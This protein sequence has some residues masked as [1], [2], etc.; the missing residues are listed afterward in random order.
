MDQKE[1]IIFNQRKEIQLLKLENAY[2]KD[3]LTKYSGGQ[4]TIPSAE[5]LQTQYKGKISGSSVQQ[6]A[7]KTNNEGFGHQNGNGNPTPQLSGVGQE[8]LLQEYSIELERMRQENA[9]L[10]MV[11][12]LKIRDYEGVIHEN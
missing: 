1:Q 4:V 11:S 6:S 12:D 3:T 10:R 9:E 7:L 8:G 2:L 5:Q